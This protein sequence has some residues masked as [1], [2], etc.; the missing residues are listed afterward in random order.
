MPRPWRPSQPQSWPR[1]RGNRRLPVRGV[2]LKQPRGKRR[3]LTNPAPPSKGEAEVRTLEE[4]LAQD[5]AP[6][7][8]EE[9]AH[10]DSAK[11]GPFET[12]RRKVAEGKATTEVENRA[13]EVEKARLQGE[14]EKKAARTHKE[15]E[16]RAAEATA[17]AMEEAY[18]KI[19]RETP[20][21]GSRVDTLG[22][23]FEGESASRMNIDLDAEDSRSSGSSGRATRQPRKGKKKTPKGYGGPP[24]STPSTPTPSSPAA[25]GMD[26]GAGIAE[27][28]R[29]AIWEW[30]EPAVE[31][32]MAPLRA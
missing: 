25:M 22:G 16:R 30:P 2:R 18:R 1:L 13:P 31:E 24:R 28:G 27:S 4:A 32:A 12:A 9:S 21:G 17:A 3:L 20:P 29:A 8:A 11:R 26:K 15:A 14:R 6:K 19:E 7:E 10:A 23:L 5:R